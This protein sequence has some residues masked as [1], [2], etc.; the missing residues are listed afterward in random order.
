VV[1]GIVL[2]VAG[3]ELRAYGLVSHF[4]ILVS[5]RVSQEKCLRCRYELS[6]IRHSERASQNTIYPKLPADFS[7]LWRRFRE[8]WANHLKSLK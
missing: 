2:W 4:G 6:Q 3:Y 8:L 7:A 5:M 1:Y